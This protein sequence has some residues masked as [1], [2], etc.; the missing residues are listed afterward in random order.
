[1]V[2]FYGISTDK[3]TYYNFKKPLEIEV[4]ELDNLKEILFPYLTKEDRK[5]IPK[6][7][8]ELVGGVLRPGGYRV[9]SDAPPNLVGP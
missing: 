4:C 2:K 3:N 1:M 8:T 5:K 7:H 9:V 6:I